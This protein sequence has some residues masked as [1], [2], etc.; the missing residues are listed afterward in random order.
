MLLNG[1]RKREAL[2]EQVLS[3]RTRD[4]LLRAIDALRD[5]RRRYPD[6][7]SNLCAG[8]QVYMLLHILD[9]KDEG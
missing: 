8:E 1:T 9:S 4:E 6:D 5:W 3:A 2:I 7:D